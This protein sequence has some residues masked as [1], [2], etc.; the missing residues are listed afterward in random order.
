MKITN[1]L[2]GGQDGLVFSPT[3]SLMP[4]HTKSRQI[5]TSDKEQAKAFGLDT[6]KTE[7]ELGGS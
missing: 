2:T 5:L 7:E 1:L 6:Q 3:D 4:E